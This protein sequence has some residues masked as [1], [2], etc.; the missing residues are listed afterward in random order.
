MDT[1][2]EKRIA[3][4]R[5]NWIKAAAELRFAIVT[6]YIHPF[7]GGEIEIFAYLPEY[8]SANGALVDLLHPPGCGTNKKIVEIARDSERF[9]S[10]INI[11]DFQNEVV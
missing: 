11:D 1:R 6:P 4:A 10:F 2:L 9:Y 5:E 3:I 7:Q 8:G